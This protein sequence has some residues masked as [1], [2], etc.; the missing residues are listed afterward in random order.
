MM[1]YGGMAA[2]AV[3]AYANSRGTKQ[4]YEAQAQVSRNNAMLAGWQA[5]DAIRRGERDASRLRMQRNQ[6]KGRQRAV[7]AAN[8]VDLGVGSAL[9]VLTDTDYFTDVDVG[10]VKDNAARE[11]WALRNQAMNFTSDAA[12]L[13]MRGGRESPFLAAGS[14]LLT[15]AG[16]VSGSWYSSPAS[17]RKT[18]PIYENPEY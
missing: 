4:A 1:Q 15:S 5:D 9:G 13:A 3:G 7:L 14:S 12:L 11:A 17:S 2:S 18:V 8:G 10:T 16:R 6:L